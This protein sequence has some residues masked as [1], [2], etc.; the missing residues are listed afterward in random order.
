MNILLESQ[1]QLESKYTAD[2][3][4]ESIKEQIKIYEYRADCSNLH[5]D[6]WWY[7]EG[8]KSMKKRIAMYKTIC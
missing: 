6:K 5:S 7:L 2:K 3:R 4:I 8:V 1:T